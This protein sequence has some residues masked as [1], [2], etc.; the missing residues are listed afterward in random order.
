MALSPSNL[1]V[2]TDAKRGG[3]NYM[4]DIIS[5]KIDADEIDNNQADMGSEMRFA[6]FAV[7]D[8]HGGAE[9][10]KFAEEHLFDEI[11]H[12]KG[13]WKDDDTSV[14]E[15]IKDG[16]MST[17]RLMWKALGRFKPSRMLLI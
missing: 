7:F 2:F 8:G 11:I 4:E 13:F 17:H 16:F 12:Q 15:A 6:F 5:T 14:V 10:A 3:R 1:V 9:A